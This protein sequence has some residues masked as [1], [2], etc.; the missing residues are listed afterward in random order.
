MHVRDVGVA[1]G[2]ADDSRRGPAR[3]PR[4]ASSSS[5]AGCCTRSRR[6][7]GGCCARASSSARPRL[8][9][10][11]GALHTPF[12]A[13]ERASDAVARGNLKVFEEIGL[14]F[15]R[16]LHECRPGASD[17]A[18]LQRFLDR[19]E[20]GEPPDG[21][22]Y[23]RQAFAHYERRRLESDPQARA[24]LAVLANLEI[25]FHEQ[26]R[27]QPEIREALDAASRHEG[28]SRAARAR[29]GV[30]VGAALVAD[31][32]ASGRRRRRRLRRRR[33]ASGERASLAR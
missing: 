22:R 20:A 28:G 13:F 18:A 27:L 3:A 16:Y 23:L 14:E 15:A 12:D 10:L 21:Q 31:R 5:A 25:G 24:Q 4:T 7:G 6:C 11:T 29:G 8:G 2:G 1:T 9:R 32:P 19:L 30:P 26:T 33:S 17:P